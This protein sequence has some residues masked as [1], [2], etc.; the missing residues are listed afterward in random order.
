M[1]L[2]DWRLAKGLTQKMLAEKLNAISG[3]T[4]GQTHVSAYEHGVMPGWDVGEAIRKITGGKVK[5]ESF[6]KAPTAKA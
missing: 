5:P 4:V 3:Q 2:K 1:T 6:V